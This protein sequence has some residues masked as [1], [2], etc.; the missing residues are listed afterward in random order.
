MD[1]STDIRKAIHQVAIADAAESQLNSA[2]SSLCVELED[3][4]EFPF[5]VVYT[6]DGVCVLDLE[7]HNQ[8]GIKN[9]L[10]HISIHGKLNLD[11]FNRMGI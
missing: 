1:D 10:V 4:I 7:N 2:L 3:R 6:T 5:D 8:A 9:V 11:S